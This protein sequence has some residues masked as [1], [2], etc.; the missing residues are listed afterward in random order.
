MAKV[1]NCLMIF[2]WLALF[3]SCSQPE[4]SSESQ[5]FRSVPIDAFAIV[6]IN[7]SGSFIQA[8][9]HDNS[10]WRQLLSIPAVRELHSDISIFDSVVS[11][12]T[13]FRETV[14]HSPVFF[15]FHRRGRNDARYM[16]YVQMKND[17]GND[18]S[19][20]IQGLKDRGILVKE[21]SYDNTEI[22]TIS[23]STKE[24]SFA[25]VGN[26]FVMS[27]SVPLIEEAIRQ[28]QQQVSLHN[29]SN[30]RKILGTA[31]KKVEGNVL[32]N[33]KQF[34]PWI[35]A[36]FRREL[37]S[38]S[39]DEGP[40]AQ[41]IGLDI[42]LQNDRL[43]LT[44]LSLA[45]AHDPSLYLQVF[46]DQAPP[47]P[48]MISIFPNT[49]SS[50]VF[51]G[52]SDTKRFIR[53]QKIYLDRNG[54]LATWQVVLSGLSNKYDIDA[55]ELFLS[56]L[57][58]EMGV[59]WTASPDSSVY[60]IL[61][62]KD[63]EQITAALRKM[64]PEE[65]RFSIK[66][67][68]QQF[69]CF[70]LTDPDLF[71]DVYR[72]YFFRKQA[73]FVSFID[74]Y[75][76]AAASRESLKEFL[77]LNQTGNRL[78]NSSNFK[79][80]NENI[81]GQSNLLIYSDIARSS[82]FLNEFFDMPVSPLWLKAF[83][84]SN[85]ACIQFSSEGKELFYTNLLLQYRA[86][87]EN[88]VNMVWKYKTDT[89]AVYPP[90]LVINHNS[91]Q[92]EV[93]TQD[94]K[95]TLYLVD[96]NGRLLWKKTLKEPIISGIVQIDYYR[97]GKLQYL[98]NTSSELHLMDRNGEY[99]KGYPVKL[100]TEAAGPVLAVDY[101]KTRDYRFFIALKDRGVYCLNKDGKAIDGWKFE[102]TTDLVT[103]PIQYFKVADKDFIVFT[104]NKQIYF[105][106]RKGDA[107]FRI[108]EPI[109]V[110]SGSGI[111]YEA[112]SSLRSEHFICADSIGNII[113]IY[114]DGHIEKISADG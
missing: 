102:K 85:G 33:L 107:R 54:Q 4:K 50:F 21:K 58:G 114:T 24:I 59:A 76:I 37:R 68:E 46:K 67:S 73:P 18:L 111:F 70:A 91:K 8:L 20:F 82:G 10:M 36:S 35:G 57:N 42:M 64:V 27:P 101:E 95:N 87:E 25:A 32:I 11:S 81:P 3:F 30:F 88:G 13:S 31:G 98:F 106:N 66:I 51:F 62:M 61:S 16:M 86:K 72:H 28:T 89:L 108:T 71:S 15:S 109:S 80:F 94:L 84:R 65:K 38:Q 78:I 40:L 74:N 45:S 69:P 113:L 56:N 29:D 9:M 34:T 103:K 7:N 112:K 19:A 52:F 47:E 41:W 110:S 96:L 48:T 90:Q 2:G 99:I 49:V 22:R 75:L 44:G 92:S 105:L 5:L 55:E 83:D 6:Q 63:K 12:N 26:L 1:R 43:M 100:K 93:M 77:Y 14:S 39:A 79:E 53:D 60:Y 17:I 97:N 104:D 23:G